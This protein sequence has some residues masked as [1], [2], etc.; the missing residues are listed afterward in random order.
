MTFCHYFH[1]DPNVLNLEI[2]HREIGLSHHFC[3][4]RINFQADFLSE[5]TEHKLE[6]TNYFIKDKS[7]EN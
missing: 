7:I 1:F 4:F 6:Q 5:N 2:R 3:L